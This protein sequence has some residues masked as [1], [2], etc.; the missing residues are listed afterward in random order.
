MID[1]Q[2]ATK[3]QVDD[4]TVTIGKEIADQL[5]DA[6]GSLENITDDIVDAGKNIL[7]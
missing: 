1:S 2:R 7:F 5:Q 6:V 4:I 3:R